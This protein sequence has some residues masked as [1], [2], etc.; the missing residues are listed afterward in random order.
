MTG[1]GHAL[2]V[3]RWA[4]TRESD[5]FPWL[6]SELRDAGVVARVA[7]LVPAP[8]APKL[9]ATV[10]SIDDTAVQE[11]LARTV[12]VAHSVGCR[13]ALHWLAELPAG[14]R[15]RALVCVAGWWSIDEPWDSIR[16]FIDEP[17]DAARAR[18]AAGETFVYLGEDDPFTGD[19]ETNAR[20]WREHM[21][22]RVM[23]VP[24]GGH[25]N[26]ESFE[27]LRD[28]VVELAA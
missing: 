12:V 1:G 10:R 13:A 20:R 11:A 25:L 28:L 24:G 26:V 5:Y 2:L 6:V 18:A 19:Q 17:L 27:E 22:A 15:V 16:P 7:P 8:D 9:A 21:G 23:M 4:G 3:P 14:A